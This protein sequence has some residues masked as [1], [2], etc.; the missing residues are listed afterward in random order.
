MTQGIVWSAITRND[1]I[2]AE[3]GEDDGT[4]KVV[5]LAQKMMKQKPTPGWEFKRSKGLRG[6]KF[7][8]YDHADDRLD[9]TGDSSGVLWIFSC[10]AHSSL[11]ECQQKSFLEKLVYLTEPL[12]QD[13]Y[14]W[15]EGGLLACQATFGP[16]LQQ[17]MEQVGH[18]GKLA[19]VNQSI[20]TT[21]E[22]MA[23]NIE[24]ALD[25]GDALDDLD[26]RADEL[27]VMS[28]QF[29]KRADQVKRFKMWQN[30]KHGVIIGTAVTAGVAV[31]TVPPL[32]ALL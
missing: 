8:V 7:H 11:E 26:K 23:R 17:R 5:S 15:R 24:M 16:L 10:I 31:V 27:N 25:R 30:A 13:D 2:L 14:L 22:I 20:N 9:S 18:H 28:Q 32:I 4:G 12:R 3:A 1:T 21:K 29:K 6:M 19:M